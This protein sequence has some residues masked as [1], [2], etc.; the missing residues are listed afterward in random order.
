MLEF[1]YLFLFFCAHIVI[2][3]SW[4]WEVAE[5]C[6]EL[7]HQVA[8][9]I[10]ATLPL[11]YDRDPQTLVFGPGIWE[12]WGGWWRVGRGKG[13]WGG[14]ATGADLPW[15]WPPLRCAWLLA[16]V[17]TQPCESWLRWVRG[18]N[19]PSSSPSSFSSSCCLSPWRGRGG[20]WGGWTGGGRRAGGAGAASRAG[21]Q[22]F[23]GGFFLT[24]TTAGPTT[25]I[26]TMTRLER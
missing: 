24:L 21:L 7:V 6:L 8:N 3:I 12:G 18:S 11:Q 2:S 17:G 13:G 26:H 20:R 23:W 19:W 10:W 15:P 4:K 5:T 25:D 14:G 22:N 9:R 1:V 16:P